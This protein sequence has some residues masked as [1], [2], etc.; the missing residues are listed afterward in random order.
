MILVISACSQK[1]SENEFVKPIEELLLKNGFDFDT[2]HYSEISSLPEYDK[3]IICGTALKDF[4]YLEN[5][6]RFSWIKKYE[7]E[8]LGICAGV[9]IIA[10]VLGMQLK[11]KIQIGK[12][13]VDTRI[14]NSLVK[15][16]FNAYFLS[17]KQPILGKEVDS[18]TQDE[19]LIKFKNKEFYGCMFHPEVLNPDIIIKF[20]NL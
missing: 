15:G 18:L 2:K 16:K 20:C 13:E 7:R 5:I 19:S 6:D 17:S 10:T 8:M 11:E 4:E 9:Q 14:A 12:K 1:L 3:V